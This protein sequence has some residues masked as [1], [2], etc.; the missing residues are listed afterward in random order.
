MLNI[1]VYID[2]KDSKECAKVSGAIQLWA[3]NLTLER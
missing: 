1:H 2:A 3:N